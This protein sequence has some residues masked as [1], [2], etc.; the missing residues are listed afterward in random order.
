MVTDESV[1]DIKKSYVPHNLPH[2]ERYFV[3][4]LVISGT[5]ASVTLIG[6]RGALTCYL[7]TDRL[8]D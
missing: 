2:D 6:L 7:Q 4:S 3:E 1:S 8:T 5:K